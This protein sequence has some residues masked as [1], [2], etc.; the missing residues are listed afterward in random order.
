MKDYMN[1]LYQWHKYPLNA[2]L[3]FIALIVLIVSLWSH[4]FLG[5]VFAFVIALIG[6]LIQENK[7]HKERIG[8]LEKRKKR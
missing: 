5:I 3:H 8:K 4:S 2:L 7:E 1:K 6:H